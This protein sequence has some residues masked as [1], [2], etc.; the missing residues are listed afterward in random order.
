MALDESMSMAEWRV[1]RSRYCACWPAMSGT[2]SSRPAEYIFCSH[3]CTARALSLLKVDP[4]AGFDRPLSLLTMALP[5]PVSHDSTHHDDSVMAS[6][7]VV[8]SA[9]LSFSASS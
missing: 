5:A 4:S 9:A 2:A 6:G 3:W 8:G 7:L 1:A